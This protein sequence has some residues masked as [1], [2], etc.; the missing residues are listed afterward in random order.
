MRKLGFLGAGNMG[1]AIIKGI[2]KSGLKVELF[3]YDKDTEKLEDI[4]NTVLSLAKA[5]RSL[6]ENAAIFCWR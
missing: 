2:V 1:S 6:R 4:K 5:K 3:A